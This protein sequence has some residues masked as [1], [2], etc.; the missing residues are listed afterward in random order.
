VLSRGKGNR[1]IPL[2]F[3]CAKQLVP[4][5]NKPILGYVLDQVVATGITQVGV[6]A[7]H[8]FNASSVFDLQA[9]L[10]HQHI[11]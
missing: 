10:H 5:A 4:V 6:I 11:S 8:F 1:L 9:A 7:A 2:A 3:T